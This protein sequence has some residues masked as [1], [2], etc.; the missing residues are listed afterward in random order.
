MTVQWWLVMKWVTVLDDGQSRQADNTHTA[1][2][3]AE[4][5]FGL[6][7]RSDI[8]YTADQA[9]TTRPFTTFTHFVCTMLD[10]V[11]GPSSLGALTEGR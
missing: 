11:L 9:Q 1:I 2:H 3:W 6:T 10:S 8:L 5:S 7:I 4:H